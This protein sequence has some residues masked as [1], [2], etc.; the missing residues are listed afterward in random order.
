M[1]LK[2]K[3]RSGRFSKGEIIE[4]FVIK[5]IY[6]FLVEINF[7]MRNARVTRGAYISSKK[8]VKIRGEHRQ[9]T[10]YSPDSSNGC[11]ASTVTL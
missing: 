8:A 11:L 5:Y 2:G 6:C 10:R 3:R 7:I 4:K 9:E 1:K